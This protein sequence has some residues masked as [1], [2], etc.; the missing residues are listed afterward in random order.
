MDSSYGAGDGHDVY[1][2]TSEACTNLV[3]RPKHVGLIQCEG[4]QREHTYGRFVSP[5]LQRQDTDMRLAIPVQV[6]VVVSILRLATYNFMQCITDLYMIGLSSS[7]LAVS[8]FC[9]AIKKIMLKKFINKPAL[10][11]MD[12]YVQEFKDLHQ[13]S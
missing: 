2:F 10:S 11:T 6:K 3:L 5:D 12:I 13:I 8:Q 4:V 1:G 7:Q 9:V